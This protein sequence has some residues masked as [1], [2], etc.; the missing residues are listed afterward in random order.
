[1]PLIENLSKG[2]TAGFTGQRFVE[3]RI[4]REDSPEYQSLNSE[5]EQARYVCV[6]YQ[7]FV[8]KNSVP[9]IRMM[10]CRLNSIALEEKRN[11]INEKLAKKERKK[12]KKEKKKKDKSRG[13]TGSETNSTGP[14]N[15][16]SEMADGESKHHVHQLIS[17]ANI[18]SPSPILNQNYV[19]GAVAEMPSHVA[20]GDAQGAE[21]LPSER[22]LQM[23]AE[24]KREIEEM[25]QKRDPPIVFRDDGLDAGVELEKLR[26][27][28]QGKLDDNEMISID[29]LHQYLLENEG[30][31]ALGDNFLGFVG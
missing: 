18:F 3:A 8:V 9:N 10:H 11:H 1:M 16:T 6:Y 4:S 29:E 13:E 27:L 19:T 15:C 30:S 31:W 26:T 20:N 22:V 14:S 2:A 17:P 5:I 21:M 28:L 25:K 7:Y 24:E 23:E 12:K